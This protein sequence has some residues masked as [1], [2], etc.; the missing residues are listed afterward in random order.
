MFSHRSLLCLVACSVSTIVDLQPWLDYR[1]QRIGHAD[2]AEIALLG[3]NISEGR[4]A[5][6]DCYWL[7]HGEGHVSDSLPRP[8]GYWSMYLG[9]WMALF[10]KIFGQTRWSLL[11]AASICKTAIGIAVGIKPSGLITLG[12]LGGICGYSWFFLRDHFTLVLRNFA[13]GL[14]GF[15]IGCFPL[16]VY[17]Y[18][19]FGT[20]FLPDFSRISLASSQQLI[21][22]VTPS[23]AFY[24][25]ELS[26]QRL[27]FGSLVQLKSWSRNFLVYALDYCS[28]VR[29]HPIWFLP[30]IGVAVSNSAHIFS[31]APKFQR[32]SVDAWVLVLILLNAAGAF[33]ALLLECQGRYWNFLV[34]VHIVIS[35]YYM[36]NLHR[37]FLYTGF[38]VAIVVAFVG[39]IATIK[40]TIDGSEIGKKEKVYRLAFSEA[41]AVIPQDATVLTSNPWEFSFHTR[42]KSVVVPY[43]PK[44][45]VLLEVARRFSADYLVIINNDTRNPEPKRLLE[46]DMPAFLNIVHRSSDLVIAKIDISRSTE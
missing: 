41:D 24:D 35:V 7:L 36:Y 11:L 39:T 34:P 45:E 21:Q 6:V 26:T 1:Y 44:P 18:Q 40:T 23:Q 28:G 12:L 27:S 31:L 5:V 3:L 13:V 4:G 8:E 25:P 43:N 38:F 20:I 10:F 29:I 32:N 14:S 46:E 9:Y 17:N 30:F 42:R 15:A 33:L 16:C 19:S 2:E 22:N 37:A